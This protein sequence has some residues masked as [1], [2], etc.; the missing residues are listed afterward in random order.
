MKKLTI[1]SKYTKT[2][3]TVANLEK[4][5]EGLN[6]ALEGLRYLECWTEDGRVTAVFVNAT[7]YE[8]GIY[9]SHLAHNGFKVVS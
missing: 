5:L 9:V 3:K 8:N 7:T 6:I 2:Y 4:A 1:N